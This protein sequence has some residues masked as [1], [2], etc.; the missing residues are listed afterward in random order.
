M[1]RLIKSLPVLLCL[2]LT[3]VS[4]STVKES[5]VYYPHTSEQSAALENWKMTTLIAKGDGENSRPEPY[6]IENLDKA[7]KVV[8]NNGRLV[9]PVTEGKVEL[10]NLLLGEEYSWK[11]LGDNGVVVKEGSFTVS[12]EPP[13]NLYVDGITNVRDLGGWEMADGSRVNQELIYRSARLSENETGEIIL[14]EKGRETLKALGIKS[15]IDLRTVNDN[16][17]GGLLESPMGEGTQYFSIPFEAG[18]GYLQKNLSS[19]PALFKVLG[20]AENYPLLFHCS[21]GT[22]RTGAV[23]FVLLSL[24]SVSEDNIYRDYL[25][26]NFGYIEGI[27]RKS[28]IDDYLLYAERYSGET[29][30]ERVYSML[31]E[32]G[33]EK[34]DI[35][36]FISIMTDNDYLF[37][38]E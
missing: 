2:V 31:V 7:D 8:I 15:E 34:S 38:G 13:R 36:N 17:N 14:T 23:S 21:I 18:G 24:L 4:C 26:S 20:D 10:Y 22:D 12:P 25:F 33:V 16:E 19:F 27:R 11:A 32:N 28:A 1:K 3:L 6:V 37:V 9:L 35:E 5:E 30:K 29:L